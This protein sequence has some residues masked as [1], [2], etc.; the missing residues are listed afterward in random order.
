MTDQKVFDKWRNLL[1]LAEDAYE[2]GYSACYN[3]NATAQEKQA[4]SRRWWSAANAVLWHYVRTHAQ[5]RITLE[6]LPANLLARLA[7]LAEE[8]SNGNVSELISDVHKIGR[9]RKWR[10]E[11]H[12]IARAIY[13][14]EAVRRGEIADRH[15]IKT[16]HEACRGAAATMGRLATRH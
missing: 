1:A 10:K 9:P 13:Y 12:D 14:V 6:P 7:N 4:A 11:R 16:V 5:E 8:L 15:P 3:E 2:A